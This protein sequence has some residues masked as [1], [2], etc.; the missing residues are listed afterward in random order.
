MVECRRHGAAYG[1]LDVVGSK[2]GRMRLIIVEYRQHRSLESK[3]LPCLYRQ[4]SNGEYNR[5]TFTRHLL[6]LTLTGAR[7]KDI[8]T[9]KCH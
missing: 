2:S 3:G 9:R 8:G 1:H 4:R 7:A 5:S 6:A